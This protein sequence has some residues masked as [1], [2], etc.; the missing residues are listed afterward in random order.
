ML[1]THG[2]TSSKNEKIVTGFTR[3]HED[4]GVGLFTIEWFWSKSLNKAIIWN[5]YK[6]EQQPEMF[7]IAQ[8]YT[9]CL[10]ICDL[11]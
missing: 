8:K 7:S 5:S 3:V 2:I 9:N 1:I 4:D 6:N 11:W 10:T